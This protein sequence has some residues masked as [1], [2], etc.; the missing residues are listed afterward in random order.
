[1]D[2]AVRSPMSTAERAPGSRPVDSTAPQRARESAAHV[3][4]KR[5]ELPELSDDMLC[6]YRLAV[7]EQ[8]EDLKTIEHK[9]N[10]EIERRLRERGARELP[11]PKFEKIAIEDDFSPY[12]P[13]FG[14]LNEA[15]KILR[16]M[17]HDDEAVKIV[18]HVAEDVTIVAEHD[19]YGN[20]VSIAALIRKYGPKSQIG[21]LL[22]RGLTRE[23]TGSRLVVKPKAVLR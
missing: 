12:V 10:L 14:A 18:K 1:M 13:D 22:T 23:K 4:V 16:A 3:A 6:D 2:S 19:E 7:V 15:A 9:I 21:E 20:P 17:G 5:F 8:R 11:H